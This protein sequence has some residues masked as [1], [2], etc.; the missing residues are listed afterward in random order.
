MCDA[1]LMRY[2]ISS[3][4]YN[5][6]PIRFI[7]Y[8]DDCV[9]IIRD[10]QEYPTDQYLLQLMKLQNISREINEVLPRDSLDPAP[11]STTA[12]TYIKKIQTKLNVFQERV[13]IH[14]RGNRKLLIPCN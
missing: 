5:M 1:K 13:P 10:I 9:D 7:K 3:Y 12:A 6:E 2:S 11:I 4:I 8:V 14:L